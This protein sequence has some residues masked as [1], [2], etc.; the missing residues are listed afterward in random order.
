LFAE[1]VNVEEYR[2]SEETKTFEGPDLVKGIALSDLASGSMLL[3]H[4]HGEPVL[5]AR[6][7]DEL[8]AIGALCTHYAGPLAAELLV[9]DKG[10]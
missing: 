10:R 4:A 3:G 1:C 7:D 8:F 2:M 6:R 9:D 5:L